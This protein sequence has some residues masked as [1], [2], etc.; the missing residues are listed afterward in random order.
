MLYG[1]IQRE[2]W[3]RQVR[4]TCQSVVLVKFFLGLVWVCHGRCIGADKG[5]MTVVHFHS[6]SS[7]PV[8]NPFGKLI[9]EL[10]VLVT[11]CKADSWL[12][13]FMSW[14]ATPKECIAR[15]V[16]FE[17]WVFWKTCFREH[18]NINVIATQFFCYYC[19]S[20]LK[21]VWTVLK[22]SDIPCCNVDIYLAFVVS[23]C[24]NS[25]STAKLDNQLAAV[26]SKFK[27]S[28]LFLG[29]L[30]SSPP[31]PGKAVL[32][33]G[34]L[35]CHSGRIHNE[36]SLQVDIKATITPKP[37]TWRFMAKGFQQYPPPASVVIYPSL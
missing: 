24:S 16:L 31:L 2:H 28:E 13:R 10:Q 26:T 19:C 23:T 33:R 4:I 3:S 29:I 30:F 1:P 27:W 35:L 37:P 8:I 36:S 32:S 20:S 11:D 18:C 22:G 7:K 9:K 17:L 25:W 14:P 34:G 12:P 6:H 21:V 5:D 15:S